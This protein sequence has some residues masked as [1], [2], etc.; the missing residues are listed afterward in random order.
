VGL[1]DRISNLVGRQLDDLI[2]DI[3]DD[4]RGHVEL[5]A[6]LLERGDYDTAIRELKQAIAKRRD[7]A[8]A[9][10]LLGQAYARRG[11]PGDAELAQK[12]LK[13][14][15]AA[16]EG[17]AE[18][19]IALGDVLRRGGELQA[20]AESYRQ[21]L[22]LI[23]DGT[24]RADVERALGG[25]YL[26]LGQI[27]KAVR[28]LRKAAAQNPEDA[29]AQG[30]LGQALVKSAQR[31]GEPQG[32]PTF[33]AARQC[34]GRA[35]KAEKPDPEVLAAL[36]A[37]LLSADQ[38]VDAEKALVRAL[39]EEPELLPAL[40]ALGQLR[41]LQGD[42]ASAYEQGLRAYAAATRAEKGPADPGVLAEVHA[43]LGRSH[44]KSGA[45]ERALASL[46]EALRLLP[47]DAPQRRPL[48]DEAL[49]LALFSERFADAARLAQSPLV[50]ESAD[51][52][53]AQARAPERTP[54][55]AEALLQ[56]ALLIG[57]TVEVRLGLAAL[58]QRKENTAAAAAQLRRAAA[59]TTRADD[60]RARTRLQALY[61][62]ERALLPKDLYGLL[63]RAHQH[64]AKNAELSAWLTEAGQLVETLD[65]PLLITVMGEFNSGKSTFVNALLGEEVAPM[66]ITPTTATINV[67]KYGRERGGRVVY[68]DGE[69][70]LVPWAKVPALLK[71]L[72]PAEAMRIRVVEVLYPLDVLSRVNVVDTPGL[73]S[74]QPEH[75]ATAREFIAQ[76]DAV[77]W[78]FT[79]DQAGKATELEAL[80]K[81]REAGKQILGVLNKIDRLP[82]M[83]ELPQWLRPRSA[84]EADD[85]APPAPAA[86]EAAPPE[87]APGAA[88]EATADPLAAILEHLNDPQTGLRELLEVIVPFSGR[89]ALRGRKERDEARLA[90][91]NLPALEQALE[92]RF[93]AR[94]QA[95]KYAAARTRLLALIDKARAHTES[96]LGES[97]R[98]ALEQALRLSQADALLFQRDTIPTER[99][100]LIADADEGHQ[101]AAR[102]TLDFVRPRRWPFG[103]NEAEP[104]DR[105]F[106]IALLE[107]KLQVLVSRS[108]ARVVAAL[109]LQ[110]DEDADLVR[111]L[112][113]QVYG[114]Y[115]AFSRGYLRGGKV[116]DFFLRVL[117]KLELTE[118]AIGRALERDAPTAIDI[119]EAELLSPLRAFGEQRYARLL[120][121]LTRKL[122]QAEL[123][124]LD[125]DERVL[126]PLTALREALQSIES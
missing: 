38:L 97:Q 40:L 42:S 72:N 73:N 125:L 98:E 25:V 9:H 28:E 23:D 18:A 103:A 76:A 15:L 53:A 126:F 8:R 29:V 124:R 46:E 10:L 80:Q 55:E 114:R 101:V 36:G 14:A 100:R 56:R 115:L 43:L 20:A 57:D 112:D 44:R 75:E 27:D 52:L 77:I 45:P 4:A 85:A 104:A 7:H 91:A 51:G 88:P 12:T 82:A 113:E 48:L 95:I 116:E 93:F 41:L 74:I 94:S 37:L 123:R 120:S 84:P 21:A 122:A 30:L 99:R 92:E 5:G 24:L 49:H 61:E 22:P 19:H 59:L 63:T 117:P 6:A 81:I 87:A 78:L 1:F 119:L 108:R 67:V 32:G 34:L 47:E 11:Q 3:A 31:R 79:V 26:L 69:S 17:Y 39:R 96:L 111:L 68:R 2:D 121:R 58:E 90:R 118:A 105:D 110:G 83:T 33:E 16:R 66:G 60:Q 107:E 89:E 54:A 13:D 64:F 71:G 50:A 65:R 109:G 102:E 86:S 70:R 106:L 62:S 35:A